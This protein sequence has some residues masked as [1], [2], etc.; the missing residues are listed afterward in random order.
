MLLIRSSSRDV[1][2]DLS[3]KAK[4]RTKD[5][6]LKTK[7]KTEYHNFVLKD[8]QGPRTMDNIPAYW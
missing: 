8:N 6:S 5:V 3:H 4:A 2:E 1:N 7:A